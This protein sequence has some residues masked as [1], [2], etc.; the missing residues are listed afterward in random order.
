LEENFIM[1]HTTNK[2]QKMETNIKKICKKELMA[3]NGG[4]ISGLII[5]AACF[6]VSPALGLLNLGV[7]N[8]Y[9][10]AAKEDQN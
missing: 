6:I 8:G 10:Q 4:S 2:N 5:D 9:R 7:K 3:T 1:K